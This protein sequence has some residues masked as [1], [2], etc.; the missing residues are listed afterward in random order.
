[1]TIVSLVWLAWVGKPSESLLLVWFVVFGFFASCTAVITAHGRSLLP[2]Q[3]VGR[4]LTLLNLG[5]MGGVFV[6]QAATG[7]V[8]GFFDAP[9]GVY[10]L[11]AYRAAFLCIA[12]VLTACALTYTFA[13]D[14]AREA[15]RRSSSLSHAE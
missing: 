8:V 11:E 10:P 12:A 2:A 9:D 15:A 3:F 5:T 4:G 6:M 7:A 14:P 1:M 13:H